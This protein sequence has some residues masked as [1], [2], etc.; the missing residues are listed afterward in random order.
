MIYLG[1][2]FLSLRK[3]LV[4]SAKYCTFSTKVTKI[5]DFNAIENGIVLSFQLLVS[6]TYNCFLNI[7]TMYPIN[8]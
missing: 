4:L 2:D 7:L 5:Y 1:I 3:V 8:F 6:I